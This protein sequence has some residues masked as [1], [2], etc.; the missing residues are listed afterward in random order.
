M[1]VSDSEYL[2]G[3]P[4][5][6]NITKMSAWFTF[7]HELI[8]REKEDYFLLYTSKQSAI[9]ILLRNVLLRQFT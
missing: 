7:L 3:Y 4:F 9:Y 2:F 5:I 8:E 1:Q 6:P